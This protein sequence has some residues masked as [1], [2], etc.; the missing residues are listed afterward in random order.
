MSGAFSTQSNEF[1][2]NK[3]NAIPGYAIPDEEG[4]WI[5]YEKGT[6]NRFLMFNLANNSFVTILKCQPGAGLAYHFHTSQVVGFTLQGEWKYKEYDWVARPGSMVFEPAGDAHTLQILGN[7]TMITLFHVMGPLIQLDTDGK[8]VGY[9]DAFNLLANC[10]DY[11]EKNGLDT[12]Y[13]EK[14]TIR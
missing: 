6:W 2:F 1:F 11:Y 3:T 8:Q 10:Y 5:E 7:E 13:L 4:V 9:V 12:S 14:I